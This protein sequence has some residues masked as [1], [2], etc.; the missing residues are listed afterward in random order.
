MKIISPLQNALLSLEKLNTTEKLRL[1]EAIGHSIPDEFSVWLEKKYEELSE[2]DEDD[3]R[4]AEEALAEYRANP[5]SAIEWND[6]YNQQMKRLKE[7]KT[8]AGH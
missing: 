3:I 6:F 1:A 7:S 4:L 5:G 2:T 8:Y